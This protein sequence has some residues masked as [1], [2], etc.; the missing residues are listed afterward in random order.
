MGRLLFLVFLTGAGAMAQEPVG[1]MRAEPNPCRIEGGRHDCTTWVAWRTQSVGRARVFVLA[2]GKHPGAEREFSGASS[3]EPHQCQAPWIEDDTRYT[4]TLVD[5][6][7]GDRGHVLASV[8]VTAG[9]QPG[10]E[11]RAEPNPCH[12]EGGKNECTAHVTWHTRGVEH[13][14]V[15]VVAEGRHPAGEKEFSTN[16]ECEGHDCRA[17]WI[18]PG[19]R[20][21]FT[22]VDFSHGDRGRVLGS[23]LVTAQR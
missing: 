5:F 19:T 4:F 9:E 8:L 11:I 21:T 3:C 10:G 16:K 14:R 13:A 23:V 17:P 18:E 2:E 12:L 6:T 20:Y 1:E 7:R 22:L 15:F